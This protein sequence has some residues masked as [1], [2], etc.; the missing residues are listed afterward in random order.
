MKYCK[1]RSK[2]LCGAEYL[3]AD[4]VTM[5]HYYPASLFV[6]QRQLLLSKS[7]LIFEE[8]EEKEDFTST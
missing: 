3:H 6:F 1:K 2:R 8:N 4:V 7:Y 5:I